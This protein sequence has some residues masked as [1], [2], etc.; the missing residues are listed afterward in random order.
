MDVYGSNISVTGLHLRYCMFVLT[1]SVFLRKIMRNQHL[2]VEFE[3]LFNEPGSALATTNKQQPTDLIVVDEHCPIY[4]YVNSLTSPNS[5]VTAR[6]VLKAIAMHLGFDSI[7]QIN[8][9]KINRSFANKLLNV[10]SDKGK[11]PDTIGLY[12]S[13]LKGVIREAF[14]LDLVSTKH[15]EAIKQV[16]RPAGSRIKKHVL[17]QKDSFDELMTQIA[18][19]GTS[20][21]QVSRDKAIFH[22]MV[23]CGL[24]R[25][26][27]ANLEYGSLN[28]SDSQVR[29]FGKGNKERH[30]VIHP[31]TKIVLLDWLAFR[32]NAPGP[33][34]IRIYKSGRIASLIKSDGSANHLSS[35]S[36]YH[37]CKKYGLITES[38]AIPPHSLRRSYATWLYN[39]GVD[40]KKIA[41]LLGHSSIKTT[42]LYVKVDDETLKEDVF[43]ALM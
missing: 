11:S 15:F 27:V 18:V 13:V 36:I 4:N 10:L 24:R 19:N 25:N 30:V 23:Y 9:H 16:K 41:K 12:L 6:R 33:L 7:Y 31:Y 35:F 32:G 20:E 39:K 8:W 3:E 26:E 21:C 28:L 17:L 43:K 2:L 1:L 34:F 37:L 29:L 22:M 40:I 42:E 5:K 14:F 38:G